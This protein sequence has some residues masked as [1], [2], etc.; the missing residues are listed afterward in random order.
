MYRNSYQSGSFFSILYSIGS[1]PLA[2]WECQQASDGYCKR[3]T[4]PDL[5][6]MV[7]EI[8]SVNPTVSFIRAPSA[9]HRSLAVKLPFITMLVKNLNRY[10]TFEIAIR[11]SENQLRRFQA[12]NF[13]NRPQF[14]MFCIKLPL[15]M[16]PNW[17]KIEINL[18][19]FCYRAHGTQYVETVYVR[20][21]ANIRIRRIYF[22][23]RLYAEEDKPLEYRLVLK[24]PAERRDSEGTQSTVSGAGDIWFPNDVPTA[25]K[26][27]PVELSPNNTPNES[28]RT[29]T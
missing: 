22:T 2:T 26:T 18:A 9:P 21:N 28:T 11:D 6:S 1:N 14:D 24:T 12:S 5:N 7:L 3:I 23:D 20:I 29:D 4:D 8:V 25:P 10:F 13:Q 16:D 15:R 17:N 27:T 19:D